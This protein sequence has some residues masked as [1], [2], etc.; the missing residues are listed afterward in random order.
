MRLTTFLLGNLV[1]I[2]F[3]IM[4]MFQLSQQDTQIHIGVL[5]GLIVGLT[6]LIIHTKI[7]AKEKEESTL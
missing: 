5:F 1:C 2:V 4:T 3:M 7:P 6:I